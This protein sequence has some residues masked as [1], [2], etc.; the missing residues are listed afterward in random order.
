MKIKKDHVAGL[1]L[2]FSTYEILMKAARL[3]TPAM[4]TFPAYCNERN[5]NISLHVLE[6][7]L[8]QNER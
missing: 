8:K 2:Q 3:A 5:V 1:G 6:K 7:E 4:G